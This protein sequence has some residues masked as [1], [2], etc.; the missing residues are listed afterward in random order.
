L[1][2]CPFFIVLM[3]CSL[4]QLQYTWN[5][6][7]FQIIGKHSTISL[8]L[9]LEIYSGKYSLSMISLSSFFSLPNISSM[10]EP[11]SDG[12]IPNR[13]VASPLPSTGVCMRSK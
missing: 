9:A 6:I 11:Q 7:A 4:C 13:V 5:Q 12:G 2:K 10:S 1:M 8:T 3:I